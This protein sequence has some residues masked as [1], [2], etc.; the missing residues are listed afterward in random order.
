M[1][2]LILSCVC[3]TTI[4]RVERAAFAKAV[5]LTRTACMCLSSI[6][7]DYLS[8]D[9][10]RTE[11]C[12]FVWPPPFFFLPTLRKICCSVWA[13]AWMVVIITSYSFLFHYKIAFAGVR[14]SW[15]I[16]HWYF[17]RGGCF[18]CFFVFAPCSFLNVIRLCVCVR[19]NKATRYI[20]TSDLKNTSFVMV[21][22]VK[23]TSSSF[24]GGC[25]W[26]NK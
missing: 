3:F 23:L 25:W 14:C 4:K 1:S 24:G 13:Q 7:P 18:V 20:N 15:L 9:N 22:S 2:E 6:N 21:C 16:L 11:G 8:C 5:S 17:I 19:V 10:T 26:G 12:L